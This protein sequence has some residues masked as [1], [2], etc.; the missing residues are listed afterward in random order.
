MPANP[1]T[2]M[3]ETHAYECGRLA[4]KHRLSQRHHRDRTEIKQRERKLL[5]A[6]DRAVDEYLNTQV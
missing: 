2:A 1:I 5:R 6:L 4:L 3:L